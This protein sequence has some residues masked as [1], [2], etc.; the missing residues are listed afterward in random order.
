MA[1][2]YDFIKKFCIILNVNGLL[3]YSD[4][5]SDYH[6]KYGSTQVGLSPQ[7]FV[8]SAEAHIHHWEGWY[9]LWEYV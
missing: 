2:P 5:E 4:K 9:Y 1:K 7:F 8:S 3:Y 6:S